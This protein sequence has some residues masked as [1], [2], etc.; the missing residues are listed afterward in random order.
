MNRIGPVYYWAGCAI[1]VVGS[2]I[3]ILTLMATGVIRQ[4]PKNPKNS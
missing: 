4:N 2:Q 3:G 1:M